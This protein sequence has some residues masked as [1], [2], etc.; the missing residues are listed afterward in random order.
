MYIYIYHMYIINDPK[1]V[2]STSNS[3]TL[4]CGFTIRQ[5]LVITNIS[6]N[7]LILFWHRRTVWFRVSALYKKVFSKDNDLRFI[8]RQ[9]LEVVVT[10][11]HGALRVLTISVFRKS[12]RNFDFALYRMRRVSR[13]FASFVAL[14]TN[15]NN[16]K[17]RFCKSTR[18]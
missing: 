18:L 1:L 2:P 11:Y 7:Y 16:N 3:L 9:C 13:K 14:T 12:T 4:I 8:Y 5:L 17:K 6:L 15:A 10:S